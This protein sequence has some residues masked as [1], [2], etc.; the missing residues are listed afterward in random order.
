MDELSRF[1]VAR[2]GDASSFVTG[3]VLTIEGS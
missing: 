1:G 2:R 3:G